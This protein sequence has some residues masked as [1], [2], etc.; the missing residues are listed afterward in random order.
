MQSPFR[1][2]EAKNIFK[3][4]AEAAVEKLKEMAKLGT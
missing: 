2:V 4:F 1:A 3:G